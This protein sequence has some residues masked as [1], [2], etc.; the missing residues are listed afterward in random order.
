MNGQQR[1]AGAADD[2]PLKSYQTILEQE[3]V[4]ADE[5]LGRPAKGLLVSGLLAGIGVG[6][7]GFLVAVADTLSF[8]VLAEP[9]HALLL[10]NAFTVGF[11]IVVLGRTDLFTEY[12][13]IA[14][15]PVLT[16]EAPVH[17]LVRLWSFVYAANLVGAAAFS[18]FTAFIAP[19]LGSVATESL[20]RIAAPL[21]AP[22]LTVILFSSLVAGWLMGLLSW[23]VTAGRDTISQIF[24]VW[25]VTFTIGLGGLHHSITGSAEVLAAV[26]V[27][28]G[29]SLSDFGRFLVLTTL[30]NAAGG[31]VFAVLI[32]YS[33][34]IRRSSEPHHAARG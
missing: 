9:V 26:F 1:R 17:K 27:G 5:E 33:L 11:I 4:Q 7:S 29:V 15:L 31:I 13:T 22:S 20:G 19:G 8:G 30:G 10:A 12:T 23:L 24:F 16:G 25:L 18:A 14:I 34:I 21:L 2:V 32:R 28:A 6:V 3:I